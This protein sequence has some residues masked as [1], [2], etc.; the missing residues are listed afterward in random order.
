MTA[1][2]NGIDTIRRRYLSSLYQHT[3]WLDNDNVVHAPSDPYGPR[4]KLYSTLWLSMVLRGQ[5]NVNTL[6]N[7]MH[8]SETQLENEHAN[9]AIQL[10]AHELDNG[11]LAWLIPLYN[12]IFFALKSIDTPC[13]RSHHIDEIM[14][15]HRFCTAPPPLHGIDV[16]RKT[17][18]FP[19]QMLLPTRPE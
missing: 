5:S 17:L 18:L 8:L 16:T 4:K 14:G 6:Y 1:E 19:P 3:F 7:L 15:M 9:V 10:R 13:F 12:C 2:Q 11:E